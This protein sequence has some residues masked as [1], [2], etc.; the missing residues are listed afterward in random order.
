MG[1]SS[2]KLPRRI[3]RGDEPCRN[4]AAAIMA[5]AIGRVAVQTQSDGE[6][7]E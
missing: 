4:L 6:G 2:G 5:T 3:K 7:V 1:V